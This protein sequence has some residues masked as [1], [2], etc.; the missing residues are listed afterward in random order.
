MTSQQT[1]PA[2]PLSA[3]FSSPRALGRACRRAGVGAFALTLPA[4]AVTLEVPDP[5]LEARERAVCE[6]RAAARQLRVDIDAGA[7]AIGRVCGR[8]R[9]DAL[10]AVLTIDAHGRWDIVVADELE[11]EC[12]QA[13]VELAGDVVREIGRGLS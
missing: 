12:A 8:L 10:T 11:G 7:G 9:A 6:T 4:G 2:A 5:C 3:P 13:L 1:H